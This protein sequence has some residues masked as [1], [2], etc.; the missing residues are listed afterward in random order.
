MTLANGLNAAA[1]GTQYQSTTGAWSGLTGG[2]A[3]TTLTSNGAGVAPSFQPAV[4]GLGIGKWV[5]LSTQQ[6]A[7]VPSLT[8]ASLINPA[9][10]EDYVFLLDD[11][12]SESIVIPGPTSLLMRASIDNGATWLSSGYLGGNNYNVV[13]S[14]TFTNLNTNTDI[15]NLPTLTFNAGI[16]GQIWFNIPNKTID[17]PNYFFTGSLLQ[18]LQ[19][20]I[21]NC[22]RNISSSFY[23]NGALPGKINAIQFTWSSGTSFA[24]PGLGGTISM[25]GI[26]K[27]GGGGSGGGIT[28]FD[29][30]TT[31]ASMTT[32]NGYVADNA[33]LVTLTLPASANI[34][35]QLTIN[36]KNTGGWIIAQNAL[37]Q[38]QLGTSA[39]TVG[40]GGSLASTNRYDSVVL[41]CITAGTSTLWTAKSA[42]N[43]TVV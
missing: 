30:T 35:D 38:I 40:V 23:N 3:G 1:E 43:L 19:P 15:L 41:Q 21:T 37:Q 20:T 27:T 42:G 24:G 28:W 17:S 5:L 18:G 13:N 12:Q 6:G 4:N 33:S 9:V 8:F 26:L 29:V 39:T 25:Y 22:I 31:S 34:G 36:G 2:A 10:Y 32:N 16:S 11:I 7:V 14:N